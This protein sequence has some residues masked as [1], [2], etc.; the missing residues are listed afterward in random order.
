M[1]TDTCEWYTVIFLQSLG[2]RE[3][4]LGVNGLADFLNDITFPAVGAN[5]DISKEKHLTNLVN[6][7]QVLTK[8]GEQIGVVGYF[9]E[10]DTDH[11]TRVG[12]YYKT[13]KVS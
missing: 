11:S 4:D 3:F 12:K 1:F 8:G 13:R 6:K 10:G 2:H 9:E 7:S 5:T